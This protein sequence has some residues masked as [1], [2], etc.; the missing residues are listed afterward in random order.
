MGLKS[1]L[2]NLFFV[3]DGLHTISCLIIVLLY[4]LL[5]Y[6]PLVQTIQ[7]NVYIVSVLCGSWKTFFSQFCINLYII[8][9]YFFYIRRQKKLT[10]TLPPVSLA[11]FVYIGLNDRAENGN[12]VWTDGSAVDYTNWMRNNPSTDAVWGPAEDGV[13]MWDRKRQRGKWNDVRSGSPLL[14]GPFICQKS[15]WMG[16]MNFSFSFLMHNIILYYIDFL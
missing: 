13:M 8:I 14:K 4:I 9:P 16:W 2:K 3:L 12:F 6:K 5:S 1:Y 15:S 10:D 7:P 11:P